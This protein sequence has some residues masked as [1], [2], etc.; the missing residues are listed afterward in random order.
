MEDVRNAV[1]ST[2][3]EAPAEVIDKY[4]ARAFGTTVGE[5]DPSTKNETTAVL[6]KLQSGSVR[7]LGK[8]GS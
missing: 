6:K 4:L 1:L 2:D 7:R 3:P 5:L 8:K